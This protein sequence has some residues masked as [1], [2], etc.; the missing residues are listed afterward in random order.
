MH[1]AAGIACKL[2]AAVLQFGARMSCTHRESM[3]CMAA[4]FKLLIAPSP[5]EPNREC[6]Y[7]HNEA[8][9]W[10]GA[11]CQRYLTSHTTAVV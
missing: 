5:L 7:A 10:A 11:A 9:S 1:D 3:S 4:L 6:N 2:A 8:D